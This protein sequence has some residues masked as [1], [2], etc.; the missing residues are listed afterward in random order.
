MY[1]VHLVTYVLFKRL[2]G[3]YPNLTPTSATAL[4]GLHLRPLFFKV[5]NAI[6]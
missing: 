4:Q 3:R 1:L 6:E 5:Y 2:A